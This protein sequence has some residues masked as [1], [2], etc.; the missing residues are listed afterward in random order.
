MDPAVG[1]GGVR[2]PWNDLDPPHWKKTEK[3][4]KTQK[5]RIHTSGDLLVVR[6]GNLRYK[7]IQTAKICLNVEKDCISIIVWAKVGPPGDSWTPLK[8]NP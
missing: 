7:Q 6:T 8:E 5:K 2:P 3:R 1:S 4:K